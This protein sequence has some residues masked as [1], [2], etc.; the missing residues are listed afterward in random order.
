MTTT[1]IPRNGQYL[2]PMEVITRMQTAFAYVETSE[3]GAHAQVLAWMDQLAFVVD[4][5]RSAAVD[6]YM[7]QLEHFQYAARFV[8]FGHNLGSDGVLLSLLMIPHQPLII[9]A[10]GDDEET[11]YLIY[12]CAGALGY[13][14]FEPETPAVELRVDP[15][16]T[17]QFA[18]AAKEENRTPS[19][20]PLK[21]RAEAKDYQ[22][23]SMF[24]QN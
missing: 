20:M 11:W 17:G 16:G 18:P 15:K 4:E 5:V 6:E 23:R 22:G 9:D 7:A 8:H 3:E 1:L 10:H 21:K 14:V 2:S 19:P 13:E 24:R 12:C